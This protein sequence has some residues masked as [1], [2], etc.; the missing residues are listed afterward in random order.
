ML[1]ALTF[2]ASF[3]ASLRLIEKLAP[4]SA[5]SPAQAINSALSSG[6]TLGIA[7]LASGPLFDAFGAFGYLATA[8]MALLGLVGAILLT[9]RARSLSSDRLRF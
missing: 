5:A 4:P 9:R 7:T 1:H 2:A 3:L 6:F 8:V